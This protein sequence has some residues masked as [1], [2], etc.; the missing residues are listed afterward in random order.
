[1][2]CLAAVQD[3][4][5]V[6]V[7]G[8]PGPPWKLGVP[9]PLITHLRCKSSIL[10]VE[11]LNRHLRKVQQ[12]PCQESFTAWAAGAR[13]WRC[14]SLLFRGSL[15]LGTVTFDCKVREVEMQNLCFALPFPFSLEC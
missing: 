8:D 4:T 1:M 3:R 10:R 6:A 11:S 9:L 15:C 12:C 5:G 2:F 14:F 13:A 7:V